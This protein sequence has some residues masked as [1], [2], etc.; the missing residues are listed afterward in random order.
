M[1]INQLSYWDFSTKIIDIATKNK[2]NIKHL[3]ILFNQNFFKSYSLS[4][5]CYILN[6]YMYFDVRSDETD[7]YF[8]DKPIL[9]EYKNHKSELNSI[10]IGRDDW[11]SDIEQNIY[12]VFKRWTFNFNVAPL[13]NLS[14]Y[15]ASPIMVLISNVL[16][17]ISKSFNSNIYYSIQNGVYW[18]DI[19]VQHYGFKLAL[20]DENLTTKDFN[21]IISQIESVINDLPKDII[22]ITSKKIKTATPRKQKGSNRTIMYEQDCLL[23]GNGILIQNG[24]IAIFHTYGGR[25][26]FGKVVSCTNKCIEIEGLANLMKA[27]QIYIIRSENKEKLEDIP[28]NKIP[29]VL[30]D[31]SGCYYI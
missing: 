29:C 24:D 26:S 18:G 16:Y 8:I 17:A 6:P 15:K 13:F 19:K 27:E 1:S 20:P 3:E 12:D 22:T 25:I 21:D 11:R 14:Y 31:K 10:L 5:N 23:D 9:D 30:N 28:W 2:T 7:L 4:K